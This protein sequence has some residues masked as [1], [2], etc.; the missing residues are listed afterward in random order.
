M[1]NGPIGIYSKFNSQ[2]ALRQSLQ[3]H[4]NMSQQMMYAKSL[5]HEKV[6]S[7]PKPII[8][9]NHV[10]YIGNKTYKIIKMHLLINHLF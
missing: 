4:M 10:H 5:A 8:C 7:F 3:R 1:I 2:W 6:K 9:Q